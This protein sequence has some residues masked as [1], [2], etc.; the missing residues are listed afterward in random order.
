LGNTGLDRERRKGG[1]SSNSQRRQDSLSP[2]RVTINGSVV[3]RQFRGSAGFCN[4]LLISHRFRVVSSYGTNGAFMKLQESE[5]RNIAERLNAIKSTVDEAEP[6]LLSRAIKDLTDLR[7]AHFP[8]NEPAVRILIAS[9]RVLRE[10]YRSDVISDEQ[11]RNGFAGIGKKVL[12]WAT[13]LEREQ[14]RSIIESQQ[15]EV[16]SDHP[17]NQIKPIEVPPNASLGD[18][19]RAIYSPKFDADGEGVLVRATGVIKSFG[20]AFR[21]GVVDVT[22]KRGE[23]LGVVGVNASGKTTLLRLLLG[24][25]LPNAGT[26]VYPA[27]E[28]H[29]TRRKWGEIKRRIARVAQGSV[30]WPGHVLQNLEFVAAAY[31][32]P[33]VD[34]K[35]NLDRLLDR[36]E[37]GRYK[38]FRWAEISGGYRTRFEIVR[39]LLSN[40]DILVLDEP[41]AYLD[42]I[43]QQI[44]LNDLRAIAASQ[45]KPIG[46]IFTSQQ[47]YEVEAIANRLIVLEDGSNQFSGTIAELKATA[48]DKLI[49]LQVENKGLRAIDDALSAFRIRNIIPSEMGVIARFHPDV[50][51]AEVLQSLSAS[52]GAELIYHRDISRSSR[53]L[54]LDN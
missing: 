37:L 32:E 41:L 20:L 10:Q 17:E 35:S 6:E 33:R 51:M 25:L 38:H 16:V 2:F 45:E 48:S 1:A 9:L 42:I 3:L 21:L 27:F 23:I 28:L 11:F 34:W 40:P 29:G 8:S 46:V 52:F 7:Q 50:S 12:D 24:D 18:K 19:Y 15:F 49:E 53:R 22:L 13:Q 36:Y 4:S 31:A 14:P 47:L 54:F 39:A 43:T 30:P 44:V 5:L 26:I